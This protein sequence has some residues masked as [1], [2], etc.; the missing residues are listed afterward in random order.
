MNSVCL[1]TILIKAMVF[2]SRKF[3]YGNFP[4]VFLILGFLKNIHLFLIKNDSIIVYN[5][6]HTRH[7]RPF[8]GEE[9]R[10]TFYTPVV[11]GLKGLG[12]WTRDFIYQEGS[13]NNFFGA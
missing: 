7:H 10:L 8:T 12:F 2:C 11:L 9:L 5:R 4:W 13:E 3:R 6:H 1:G